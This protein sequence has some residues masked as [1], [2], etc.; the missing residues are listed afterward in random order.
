M[1]IEKTREGY[2]HRGGRSVAFCDIL[3]SKPVLD[4]D[5][6]HLFEEK[7]LLGFMVPMTKVPLDVA[8]IWFCIEAGWA[9]SRS[10]ASP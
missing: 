7:L 2:T 9:K 6:L 5:R 3:H 8:R 1:R 10:K 4:M